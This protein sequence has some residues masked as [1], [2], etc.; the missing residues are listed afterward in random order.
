[1]LVV[2]CLRCRVQLTMTKHPTVVI[3][4]P[5]SWNQLIELDRLPEPRPQQQVA[6]N[7]WNTAGGTSAGKALHLASLGVDTSLYT[8]I[9]SDGPG[10]LLRQALENTGIKLN[11]LSSANT[12]QHVN[13]MAGGERVSIYVAT[14]SS[15]SLEDINSSCAAVRNADAAVV[16]L[17]EL[18]LKVIEFCGNEHPPLWVDL[19]DYDGLKEFHRPFLRAAHVAFMN[20]DAAEDPW[21]LLSICLRGGP[22][23]AICTLGEQG[24]IAMDLQ[25]QRWTVPAQKVEVID[26]NGAG[27]AF[28]AGFMAAHLR[29]MPVQH[30]LARAAEQAASAISTRHLHPALSSLAG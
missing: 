23:L 20:S 18:G 30:S 6:R 14:P 8:P 2:P 28:M 22:Q 4:G 15:P 21:E 26:T 12:E 1:M 5:T 27:D 10:K 16:D 17:S 7:S 9:G 19:H 11:A 29:G 13:L 25:G 24:A 3:C